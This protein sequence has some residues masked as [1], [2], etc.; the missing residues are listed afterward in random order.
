M[1]TTAD[2]GIRAFSSSVNGVIR[3]VT[4]GM[5]DILLSELGAE[6]CSSLV[7]K[8]GEWSVKASNSNDNTMVSWLEEVL[9]QGEVEGRWLVDC[10]IL[11][12]DNSLDAQVSFV[13]AEKIERELEIK[14]VTRHELF[15][16]EIDE[17]DEFLG[18]DSNIPSF[19]GPGW[20]AQLI[21]DI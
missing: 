6:V 2:I 11:L 1:P 8:S 17:G 19:Q 16:K 13:D 10:N 20:V 5:Q 14:A 9:Y 12:G 21:F 4:L 3:E 18:V 7:C 15:L